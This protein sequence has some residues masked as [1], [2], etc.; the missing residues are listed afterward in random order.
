MLR[1]AY[2]ADDFTGATDALESLANSGLR[3]RLFLRVPTAA[4]CQGLDAIGVAGLTRSLAPDAMERELRPAFQSLRELSPRHVHYKVCST[5]DSSPNVGNIGRAIEI[6]A[7]VFERGV[8]P[9][10]VAAPALGRYCAFGNLFARFGIGSSGAIHRLDRHPSISR[11]PVT[12]MTEA[13]LRVHLSRQTK[14]AIGLL[15][16]RALEQDAASAFVALQESGDRII[17]IDGLNDGHLV[18]AGALLDSLPGPTRYIVGSSGVGTALCS[19]W[20]KQGTLTA[21]VEYS[22]ADSGSPLLVVSGSCSVVTAGQIDWAQE[23]GFE[24]ISVEPEHPDGPDALAKVCGSLR[25]GRHVIACTHRAYSGTSAPAE[26]IGA[27]L[28]RLARAAIGATGACRL[29]VA[30]G[31]TSS[32]AARA[33]GIESLEMVAPLVPGAPLCRAHAPG[34][35]VDGLIVNFKGG[36]VG[37]PGYFA[38]AAGGAA[39]NPSQP[40]QRSTQALRSLH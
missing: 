2:Y 12:P 8:V 11:H 15:D 35:P 1:L 22:S 23:N 9:V 31:D 37:A 39:S 13:D 20:A 19:H 30:G 36:Q 27:G 7:E 38:Q 5:F 24:V 4:D 3:T 18:R 28:G 29:V 34:S 21:P 16:F 26:R 14:L 33:L 17:L 25:K 10:L 32:Y 40:V 6:G